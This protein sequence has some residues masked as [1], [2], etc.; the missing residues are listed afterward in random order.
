MRAASR[1][2]TDCASRQSGCA[3]PGGAIAAR[4]R[5]TR[6]SELVT[7]PD[8]SG[9]VAAGNTRSAWASV[10]VPAYASC[11]ITNSARA[12]AARTRAWSGSDCAGLVAAI[13]RTLMR[14]S[15]TASNISSA[16]A[17]GASGR[18]ST[19]HSRATSARCA[20]DAGS[21]WPGSSVAMPPASRP[22]MALGCPVSENGPAPG[23]PI[24]PVA[25][26][27]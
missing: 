26:C 10:S 5:L 2:A 18:L 3:S 12:N 22:P 20:A 7:V 19:P 24:C 17:P 16:V 4:T 23:R 6:R 15:A 14:P 25:R 9:Q 8:F 13:H 21:R 27:R 11:T 1:T